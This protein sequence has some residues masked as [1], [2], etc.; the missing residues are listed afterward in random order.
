MELLLNALWLAVAFAAFA[1]CA[2]GG[3]DRRRIV[4]TACLVAL[5]FPI[6]SISDDLAPSGAALNE[7]TIA[8]R[9]MAA[10]AQIIV[11]LAL[12]FVAFLSIDE[13]FVLPDAPALALRTLRGPPR[14]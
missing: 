1:L 12:A 10:A 9:A 7:T 11:A 2:R 3:S 4:V 13:S 6:I 14:A 8:Q 5:L